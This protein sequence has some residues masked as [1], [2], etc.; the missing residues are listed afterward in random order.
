MLLV[1]KG[2]LVGGFATFAF[3]NWINIGAFLSN[4]HREILNSTVT[5]CSLAVNTTIAPLPTN[6]YVFHRHV[7]QIS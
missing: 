1:F 7:Y 3:T 2:A 6:P 4:P 5:N